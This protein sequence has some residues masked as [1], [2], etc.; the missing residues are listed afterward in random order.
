MSLSLLMATNSRRLMLAT[1]I[2]LCLALLYLVSPTMSGM[3]A[4]REGFSCEGCN[5]ILISIDTLRADHLPAYGYFQDTSP[6]IDGLA[7][8]GVVFENAYSQI[9][10]TP[11]SHWSMMSGLYPFHHGKYAP[12]D[13][14]EGVTSLA[15]VLGDEG[16]STAGFVG[17]F[18]VKSVSDG[19]DV[20]DLQEGIPAVKWA[21]DIPELPPDGESPGVPQG[22]RYR[23]AGNTTDRALS[24]LDGQDGRFFLFLHYFDVHMPYD[25]P[26]E[27][28]VFDYSGSPFY[29]DDIYDAP[30]TNSS[31][32]RREDVAKYDGEIRYIDYSIG[33][34]VERLRVLGLMDNTI[35]VI[36][37]DHGEGFGEHTLSQFG[38]GSDSR[39]TGHGKTL[40]DEEV[41]VPL[42]IINPKGVAGIRVSQVVESVDIMPTVLEMLGID[43]DMD[44]D[45][46]S[47]VPLAEGLPREK[48][49]AMLETM[50][51]GNVEAV[52]AIASGGW[53]LVR[54]CVSGSEVEPCKPERVLLDVKDGERGNVIGSNLGVAGELDGKLASVIGS[55]DAN[56]SG[57]LETLGY[58]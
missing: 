32:T 16:Y 43:A 2:I 35:L 25:P 13:S 50:P 3:V 31:R 47:M 9:P 53:K 6:N 12:T 22:V 24:W 30:G 42:I 26:S 18:M 29:S 39:V 14:G 21:R 8:S 54:M 20:Y 15:E 46:E 41:H 44:L 23:R 34:V 58:G 45:G 37:A 49:Y 5:V 11:P 28:D 4:E 19:F 56:T 1:V 57:L 33:R 10:F 52:N 17:S 38:F 36:T 40:F 55:G 7:R 51:M 27:F 48:D